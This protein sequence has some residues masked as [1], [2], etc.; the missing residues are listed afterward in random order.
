MMT[1]GTY[2]ILAAQKLFGE[3]TSLERQSLATADSK[4]PAAAKSFRNLKINPAVLNA[5]AMPAP[6][7]RHSPGWVL[8]HPH[9]D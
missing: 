2:V 4:R 9:S 3:S 8:T 6:R 5:Q 7:L 1:A